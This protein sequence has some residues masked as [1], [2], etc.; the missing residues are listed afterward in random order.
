VFRLFQLQGTF[1]MLTTLVLFVFQAW[2]FIDAVSRR[3]EAFVAADKL[4]KPAWL[5]IL[6]LALVAHMLIW[7]PISLLNLLGTVAA[8]VYIVDARP[9]MKSLTQR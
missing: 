1:L 9:A 2:A 7:N 6:G 4:T 8:I 3:P 5:L